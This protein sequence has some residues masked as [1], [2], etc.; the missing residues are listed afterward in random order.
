MSFGPSSLKLTYLDLPSFAEST[1]GEYLRYSQGHIP[2][3]ST[4][5]IFSSLAH[6]NV[7][8]AAYTSGCQIVGTRLTTGLTCQFQQQAINQA[9]GNI[10]RADFSIER[11][12]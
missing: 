3:W 5:D 7:G 6:G 11:F 1:G 12:S 2:Y 4:L 9:H 10:T 8:S